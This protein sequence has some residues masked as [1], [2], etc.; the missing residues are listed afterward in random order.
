MT[1]MAPSRLSAS[2]LQ[3]FGSSTRWRKRAKLLGNARPA[4]G[5]FSPVFDRTRFEPNGYRRVLRCLQID[6]DPIVGL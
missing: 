3:P 6:F 2:A 1:A 4:A 5:T